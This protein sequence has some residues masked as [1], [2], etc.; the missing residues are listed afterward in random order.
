[1]SRGRPASR[2][3]ST[4]APMSSVWMWQFHSPSPPDHDDRVADARP[5]LLEVGDRVVGG[6]E[7]VHDLVAQVAQAALRLR[8]AAGVAGH[9]QRPQ[10]GASARAARA[11][12]RPSTTQQEGVEEQQVAGAAGVDHPGPGQ[13]L[14]QL[15]GPGQ[16]LGR[17]ASGRPRPPATRSPSWRRADSAPSPAARATVRMVPSTG[18]TTAWRARSPAEH[19]RLGH[20]RPARPPAP[21]PNR[22]ASPRSSW[23][24]ITPEL[25]RAP[26]SDPWAT[27]LQTSAISAGRLTLVELG[28]PRPRG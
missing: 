24:R 3:A 10:V 13:D 2:A 26:M 7:E 15:G 5:H 14:E 18:R 12:G 25:P 6:L 22:S 1:M 16:R 27:A 20:R 11:A 4:A 28:R 21:G 9:G 8:A 23:E 19:Q 17:P